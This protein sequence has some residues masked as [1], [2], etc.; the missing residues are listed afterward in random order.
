MKIIPVVSGPVA[1]IGYLV[2]DELSRDGVIIDT[3]LESSSIFFDE[4]NKNNI[5][6]KSILLTHTHWDHTAD[7]YLI[8]NRTNAE[9]YV[10]KADEYRLTDPINHMVW[11]LPI[12]LVP[13]QPDK[14][15]ADGDTINCGSL[16]FDV[17]HTP[18]H[19]EGGV[20]FINR[21]EK[22]IFAGDT[23]FKMSIGRVDL[24]GGNYDQLINSINEKLMKMPDDFTI[25]SGH[26]EFTTIGF[27]RR[28]NPYLDN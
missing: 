19:T 24:P 25:Y 2:F 22:V 10:H 3:P 8:K 9:I 12:K 23:L 1:T 28:N 17:V 15:L 11:Q 16:K 20:C 14:Y 6:L 4:I 5:N 26:G 13:T 21:T 27:E 18:G 7:A